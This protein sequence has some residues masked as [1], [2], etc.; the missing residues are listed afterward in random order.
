[1]TRLF[2]RAAVVLIVAVG[3]LA[4]RSAPAA[5]IDYEARGMNGA[6][7]VT[8]NASP[9]TGDAFV[10]YDNVAHTMRVRANFSGLTG[11][12]TAAHI[13]AP[14]ST[15]FTGQAGVAT[16]QPS[17]TGFPLGVTSGDMDTTFD[18]TL[19]SSWGS[20]FLTANGNS[21]A[22]AEAAFFSAMDSGRAY[23]NVHSST[24]GG[25]EIRQFFTVV[26]EPAALSLLGAGAVVAVVRRRRLA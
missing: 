15:P 18:L 3:S 4:P 20:G 14:T 23:F 5:V 1:M 7:E 10:T 8:P 12:T 25:G 24:F 9:G 22:A 13:H 16:Q 11:T 26:P 19:A 2:V 17:F 21:P 6:I